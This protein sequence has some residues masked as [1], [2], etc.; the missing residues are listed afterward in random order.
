MYR[1]MRS[2][3]QIF[4]LGLLLACATGAVGADTETYAR[5]VS[6][7]IDPAK[8]ATLRERGANPRVQKYVAQLA[9]AQL[10]HIAPETL[11]RRSGSWRSSINS[12]VNAHC[13]NRDS[14]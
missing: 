6:S 10:A 3:R 8:L 7:L 4:A 12:A 14:R 5:K 2:I 13:W 9:E 1:R 11:A